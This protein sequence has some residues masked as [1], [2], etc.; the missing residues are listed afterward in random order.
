MLYQLSYAR[1]LD[2]HCSKASPH[3]ASSGSCGLSWW[4]RDAMGEREKRRA[5]RCFA[6]GEGLTC[7]MFSCPP[8][9]PRDALGLVND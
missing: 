4:V 9:L 2:G 7:L 3:L 6:A 1:V 5:S 8:I